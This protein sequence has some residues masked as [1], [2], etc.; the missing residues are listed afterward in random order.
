MLYYIYLLYVYTLYLLVQSCHSMLLLAGPSGSSKT[1]R[2]VKPYAIWDFSYG[3]ELDTFTTKLFNFFAVQM[4]HRFF[5]HMLF[6]SNLF[7]CGV[8]WG[9][10]HL[11]SKLSHVSTGKK[12]SISVWPW[13][14]CGICKRTLTTCHMY[15]GWFFKIHIL[16]F[17]PCVFGYVFGAIPKKRNRGTKT[18][19]IVSKSLVRFLT[20]PCIL[21][22]SPSFTPDDPIPEEP[23]ELK[24]SSA[25]NHLHGTT[26]VFLHGWMLKMLNGL[27]LRWKMMKARP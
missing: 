8:F 12:E 26:W 5:S 11:F 13:R 3:F 4:A 24:A 21:L 22:L 10:Y 16:Y 23:K 25:E 19:A 6:F 27:R 15:L 2:Y 9:G 7:C 20:I 1:S 18:K 14:K 17:T